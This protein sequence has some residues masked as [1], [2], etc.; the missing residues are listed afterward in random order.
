MGDQAD[1]HRV[2]R[3]AQRDAGIH[4]VAR[5]GL[6]C[7]PDALPLAV[8]TLL[9]DEARDAVTSAGVVGEV[10]DTRTCA[11]ELD[12]G[13]RRRNVCAQV[14]ARFVQRHPG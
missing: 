10:D 11:Q 14:V 4:V 13:P 5:E 9:D 3:G 2:L 12:A 1:A 8:D 7:A 6:A